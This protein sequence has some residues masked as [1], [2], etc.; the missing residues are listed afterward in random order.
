LFQVVAILKGHAKK[1][2]RVVYHTTEDVVVT[3][4]HDATIRV[5][6]VSTSH[7]IKLMRIH[8][9]PVTG[10]SLHATG[11]YILSTSTD[12]VSSF[13]ECRGISCLLGSSHPRPMKY[14]DLRARDGRNY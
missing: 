11:D 9:G 5:W 2:N 10:L 14:L 12:H 6:D 3:A 1:V 13:F 8:E 7:T 4:S